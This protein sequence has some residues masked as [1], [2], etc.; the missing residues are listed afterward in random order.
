MF[1]V[2]PSLDLWPADYTV[3]DMNL[4]WLVQAQGEKFKEKKDSIQEDNTIQSNME[5]LYEYSLGIFFHHKGDIPDMYH[6]K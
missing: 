2:K 5:R 1:N 6:L 3:A 4:S